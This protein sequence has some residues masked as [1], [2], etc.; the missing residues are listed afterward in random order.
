MRHAEVLV[1]AGVQPPARLQALLTLI[2]GAGGEIRDPRDRDD[3]HPLVIPLARETTGATLGLLRWPTPPEGMALPVVRQRS[4]EPDHAWTLEL[5][6]R[7]AQ[8]HIHRELALRDFGGESLPQALLEA[9]DRDG[10]L[11]APGMV[12]ASGLP[13]QAYLLL[14]VGETHTFFEA[15]IEKHL[16][17]GDTMAAQVTADRACRQHQG[18]ARPMAARARLLEALGKPE[19]ARDSAAAA[20]ADAIWT[21][22]HSFAEIARIAGWTEISGEPFF[23]LA[24]AEGKSAGDRAAHLM[25]GTAADKGAWVDIREELA[26]IYVE[27]EL[28]AVAALVSR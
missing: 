16:Q 25:D 7:S 6:S 19:E 18:W 24:R 12:R 3:L 17:R 13:L 11:Y 21:L 9:V 5:V 27:A 14:K 10:V 22:G 4:E 2:L 8:A 15:L 1:E 23:R 26:A 20:L 28:P